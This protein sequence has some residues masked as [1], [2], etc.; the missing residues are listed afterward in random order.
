MHEHH[1]DTPTKRMKVTRKT[2]PEVTGNT[3]TRITKSK[4]LY[5]RVHSVRKGKKNE[6]I[7]V[8]DK[9]PESTDDEKVHED[10]VTTPRQQ[11]KASITHR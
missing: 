1:Q 11:T 2:P 6:E 10:V 5:G 3:S 4:P 7:E 9:T 8:I